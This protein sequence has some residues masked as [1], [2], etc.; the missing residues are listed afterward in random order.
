MLVAAE[1]IVRATRLLPAEGKAKADGPW[2]FLDLAGQLIELSEEAPFGAITFTSELIL[3]AQQAGEPVGWISARQSIFYPPDFAE[4]GIDLS[5]V[6]IVSVPDEAGALWACDLL[7]R[8]GAFGFL[9]V[10]IEQGKRWTDAAMARLVHLA[11]RNRTA[12]LFLTVKDTALAS[13]S[14]LVTLRGEVLRRGAPPVDGFPSEVFPSEDR[15]LR[16]ESGLI[17]SFA[18]EIRTVKDKRR[19]PGRR[20]TRVYNGPIGV[21]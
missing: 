18:C 15:P 1:K 7:L 20:L 21:C 14:S 2:S 10:D 3:A 19:A 5:A 9:I 11:R 12:V 17:Q 13:L 4:N 16:G 8:S 6:T